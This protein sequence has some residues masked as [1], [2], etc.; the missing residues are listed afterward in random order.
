MR[1]SVFGLGYVGCVSIGCLAK[2]G[3]SLIGV[4]VSDTK[5]EQLNKGEPTIIEDEIDHLIAEGQRSG[6]ISATVDAYDAVSQSEISLITVGTPN[7]PNGHLDLVSVRAVSQSIGEAIRDKSSFHVVVI[8][9]TVTP[10]TGAEVVRIIGAASG[11][12]TGVDFAVVSNPEFL[13][14][15]SAVRDFF[16]PG[17]TVIGTDDDRAYA[18]LSELYRDVNGQI[19]RVSPEVA[20]MIKYAN[21]AFHA[22]KVAF[23]NEIGRICG[24]MGIDSHELM[25][26]FCQDHKL[27][28]SPRYLMPGAPYGGS[29]LPKDLRGLQ[30]LA[31]D[32]YVQVPV[33]ASI[34]Q[35][36]SMQKDRVLHMVLALQK[37]RVGILGLSF[38]K[39]TDDLRNSPAV[40]LVERLVGKGMW[41]TVYDRFVRL[42]RLN[43][44]N[45][46]AIQ[47]RVPK[48]GD[49][50][51][52]TVEEVVADSDVLVISYD[53]EE[54]RH[55]PDAR[56]D[57]V[58]VDA[59]R[60]VKNKR[61]S[62]N[63]FGV[64]W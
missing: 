36:N 64:A 31:H 42:A 40:E 14:E 54:F 39:G 3:H 18:M 12:K 29:C 38:K 48:I 34:E 6:C 59:A 46:R 33:I 55:L 24:A 9:S 25:E 53:D 43:G 17:I 35:S 16:E 19:V 51:K 2:N 22:L 58:F 32:N 27:N 63:Y 20:E 23:G 45:L 28:I 44:T 52:A 37:Q 47:D 8:R 41:V 7:G 15:G 10:G 5:V 60:V 49:Y 4:D 1:I 62:G 11:K 57:K 26:L 56:P 50:L 21:N 13:R 61:T 30:T